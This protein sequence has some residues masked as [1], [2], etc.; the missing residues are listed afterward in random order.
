MP[1]IEATSSTL[2]CLRQPS[3]QCC[4]TS[5]RSCPQSLQIGGRRRA[6]EDEDILA[7][8]LY[9]L[10]SR[11]E[12]QEI[13]LVFGMIKSSITKYLQLGMQALYEALSDPLLETHDLGAIRF[14]NQVSAGWITLWELCGDAHDSIAFMPCP[15]LLHLPVCRQPGCVGLM[16]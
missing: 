6:L 4:R 2:A 7:L 15:L 5:S 16:Q 11:S 10:N 3:G 9:Y 8:T 13:G 14:P 12:Q 1:G